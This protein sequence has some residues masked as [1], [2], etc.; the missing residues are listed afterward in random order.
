[1]QKCP[2][3]LKLHQKL[4]GFTDK[5]LERLK[6][7]V[8]QNNWRLQI[9]KQLDKWITVESIL[10][11]LEYAEKLAAHWDHSTRCGCFLSGDLKRWKKSC[12]KL[13]N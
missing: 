6:K 8:K 1:M 12:G 7:I 13:E 9:D 11:R 5:D 2:L 4:M 10:D 3:R